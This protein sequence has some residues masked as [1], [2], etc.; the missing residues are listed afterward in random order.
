MKTEVRSR[1]ILSNAEVSWRAYDQRSIAD[2]ISNPFKSRKAP[3]LKKLRQ[4]LQN[5]LAYLVVQHKKCAAHLPYGKVAMDEVKWD[6]ERR[7]FLRTIFEGDLPDRALDF[8]YDD[9]SRVIDS[10]VQDASAGPRQKPAEPGA[11]SPRDFELHCATVLKKA[12]GRP[13]RCRAS[14]TRV[15]TSWQ[16][17]TA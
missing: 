5:H 2:K 3:A 7:L 13:Q 12:G 1:T 15:L 6:K 9:F 14:L 17:R 16:K 10:A 4:Q 8:F 11:M